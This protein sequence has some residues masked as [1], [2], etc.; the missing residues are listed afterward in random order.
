MEMTN[1]EYDLG[2]LHR[3]RANFDCAAKE[4]LVI[5][6]LP[7]VKHIVR[8]QLTAC[9]E[10]DDLAQE[11]LIGLLRAIEEYDAEKY[12]IKFSTFAYI[13]ILRKV[14]NAIKQ[15]YST[16][17]KILN[18]AM[19]LYA[20]M[21]PDENRTLID[22]LGTETSDPHE[23]IEDQWVCE[24]LDR[25]LQG[26]LSRIEYSVMS[27]LLTGMSA[28]EIQGELGLEAKVI[29]NARTRA[30]LKLRRLVERYGSLLD[31]HLPLKARKRM[32][33]AMSLPLQ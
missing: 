30:R 27:M 15:Y 20:H 1:Q 28:G 2:L 6:Y 12:D 22:L 3:I 24:R 9:L 16:K 23:I 7:M 18:N 17:N 26:H 10:F 21:N 14:F 33:L 29:D 8:N 4:E 11:G 13:C 19:S 32:D 5:K 25:V 31:P